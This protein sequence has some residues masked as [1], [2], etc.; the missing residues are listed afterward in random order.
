MMH[1]IADFLTTNQ[2]VA[3]PC[4]VLMILAAS[5]GFPVSIDVMLIIVACLAADM[6]PG[7]ITILLGAFALSCVASASIAYWIGRFGGTKFRRFAP[8]IE[9]MQKYYD[10]FG[11]WT[12]F[13]VRFVPF[14]A[15][16]IV[17]Y[18]SGMSKLS[19]VKFLCADLAA[20]AIWST[21]FFF[22]FY[23]LAHSLEHLIMHQ[24][25]INISIFCAFSVTVIGVI[26]YKFIKQKRCDRC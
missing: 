17:Y 12:V 24:T 21:L 11:I 15:R 10:R 1:R 23:N 26:C 20:C 16:N 7:Q 19:Y 18:T 2:E 4:M 6:D 13:F 5:V 22:I 8:L 3:L 9:K 14:G 25:W